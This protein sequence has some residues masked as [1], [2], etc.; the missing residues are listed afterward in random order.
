MLPNLNG[1]SIIMDLEVENKKLSN[2]LNAALKLLEVYRKHFPLE[3]LER[4]SNQLKH[5][6][7]MMESFLELQTAEK[8]YEK[9]TSKGQDSSRIPSTNTGT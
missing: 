9:A 6:P 1:Q 7:E 8:E 2:D 4:I 5:K 3:G